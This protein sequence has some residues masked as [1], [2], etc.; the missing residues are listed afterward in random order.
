MQRRRLTAIICVLLLS[1][2]TSQSGLTGK[3]EDEAENQIA[4]DLYQT[5]PNIAEIIETVAEA[6]YLIEC[7]KMSG[8]G[9][10]YSHNSLGGIGKAIITN[11]HVIAN[12]LAEGVAPRVTDHAWDEFEAEIVIHDLIES[13]ADELV[14]AQDLAILFPTITTFEAISAYSTNFAIGSWVMTSSYPGIDPEFYTHAITTGNI[15]SVSVVDGIIMTAAINPGS[16]GGVVVNSLGQVL[17]TVYSGYPD[18]DLND[19]GFFLP[20]NRVWDLIR[21]IPSTNSEG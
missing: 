8:S 17:G 9:W 2:C 12:C 11:Q 10:G 15:A 7:P 16:S 4:V 18:R 13:D 20:I 21:K 1:A 6:T 19:T 5:P 14:D 3:L